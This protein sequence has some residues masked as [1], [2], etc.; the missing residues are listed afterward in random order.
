MA[1]PSPEGGAP[2]VPGELPNWRVF[3]SAH[4]MRRLSAMRSDAKCVAI[5]PVGERT[6]RGWRAA[7]EPQARTRGSGLGQLSRA[8]AQCLLRAWGALG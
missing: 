6:A 8:P 1:S 5:P 7:L 4:E 3:A 2:L